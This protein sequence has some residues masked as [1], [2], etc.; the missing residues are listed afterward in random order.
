MCL[1]RFLSTRIRLSKNLKI[2]SYPALSIAETSAGST[3]TSDLYSA[4]LGGTAAVVRQR[5]HILDHHNLDTVVGQGADGAFPAGTRTFHIDIHLFQARV[6]GGLGSVRRSHLGCIGRVLLGTLEAHLAGAAPGNDLTILVGE[7]DDDVVKAGHD[8][9][10]AVNIHFYDPFLSSG[11][12]AGCLCF[13]HI[14]N[15]FLATFFLPAT[16]LRLPL[17]VRLLVRVRC[18]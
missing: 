11:F 15:Y 17:R 9:S 8:V 6:N 10:V 18:P 16:V 7:A 13:C 2:E 3:Y 12:C 14:F 5:R 1:V 4:F